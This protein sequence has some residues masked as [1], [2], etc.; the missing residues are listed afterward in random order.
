MNQAQYEAAKKRFE[1]Y[2]LRVESPTLSVEAAYDAVIAEKVRAERDALLS[3]T[4]FRM[5]SDAPWATQ[6]WVAYRQAL[7][8]IPT[9]AGFPQNVQWPV[10]P[11]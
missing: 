4:D 7:R 2:D 6:P 9:S 1:S 8:D 10:E 11:S 5:V 3:A